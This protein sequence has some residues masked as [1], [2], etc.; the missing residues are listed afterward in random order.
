MLILYQSFRNELNSSSLLLSGQMIDHLECPEHFVAVGKKHGICVVAESLTRITCKFCGLK[1]HSAVRMKRHCEQ[2]HS[3][4]LTEV[5]VNM[6]VKASKFT[7]HQCPLCSKKFRVKSMLQLH[8]LKV[9][10]CFTFK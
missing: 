2:K 6:D 9:C 10:F 8:F 5:Q 7:L 1:M 3:N 4:R